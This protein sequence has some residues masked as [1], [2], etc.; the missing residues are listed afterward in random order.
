M[1]EAATRATIALSMRRSRII[2]SDIYHALSRCQ[3]WRGS[4]SGSIGLTLLKMEGGVLPK[5]AIALRGAK[6]CFVGL[7]FPRFQRF[8]HYTGLTRAR[9]S[10]AERRRTGLMATTY[11]GFDPKSLQKMSQTFVR[12]DLKLLRDRLTKELTVTECVVDAIKSPVAFG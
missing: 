12:L 9:C 11:Y 4:A 5:Y 2:M 6:T 3:V 1:E 10:P 7:S 8:L